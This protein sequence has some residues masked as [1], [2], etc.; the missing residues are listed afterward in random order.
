[1][2][3]CGNLHKYPQYMSHLEVS[4]AAHSSLLLYAPNKP[5]AA[6]LAGTKALVGGGYRKV[7]ENMGKHTE[8]QLLIVQSMEWNLVSI[9]RQPQALLCNDLEPQ[10]VQN[11]L[12]VCRLETKHAI[13]IYYIYI[14]NYIIK[15]DQ[16]FHVFSGWT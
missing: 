15:W 10:E 5:L 7:H 2:N 6:S 13:Q 12:V 1:M 8:K 11:L 14:V 4:H 16:P 9:L 3:Y